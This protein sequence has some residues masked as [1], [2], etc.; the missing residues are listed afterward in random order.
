MPIINQIKGVLEEVRPHLQMDGGDVEFVSFDEASGLLQVR[1]QGHCQ[2]CPMSL[3]TLKEGIGRMVKEKISVVK[4][5]E[6]V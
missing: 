3:I 6:A 2:G 1:L 4:E 5:V